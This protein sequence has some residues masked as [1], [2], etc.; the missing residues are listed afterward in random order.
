MCANAEA[1]VEVIPVANQIPR[2]KLFLV[3]PLVLTLVSNHIKEHNGSFKKGDKVLCL[4]ELGVLPVSFWGGGVGRVYFYRILL[5]APDSP[6]PICVQVYSSGVVYNGLSTRQKARLQGHE[7]SHSLPLPFLAF[8]MSYQS[9]VAQ[10]IP[11]RT[12]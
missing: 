4:L 7:K 8:F 2:F 11:V 1:N 6:S 9:A 12:F 5:V 10:E 3:W